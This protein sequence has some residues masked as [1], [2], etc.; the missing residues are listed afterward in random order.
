MAGKARSEAMTVSKKFCSTKQ[1]DED[2][3]NTCEYLYFTLFS[4]GQLIINLSGFYER[5][6]LK[7]NID[8]TFVMLS[9]SGKILQTFYHT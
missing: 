8:N 7:F 4:Q 2:K 5:P 3:Q 6:F 9:H 1:N